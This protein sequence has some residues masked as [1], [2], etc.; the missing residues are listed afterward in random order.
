MTLPSFLRRCRHKA[1]WQKARK[2]K[3]TIDFSTAQGRAPIKPRTLEKLTTKVLNHTYVVD[4]HALLVDRYRPKYHFKKNTF[5][6][7]HIDI[8]AL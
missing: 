6:Y 4:R 1:L 3:N 8:C 2:L 5:E 7:I